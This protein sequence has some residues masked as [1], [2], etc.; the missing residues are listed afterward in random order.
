VQRAESVDD[1]HVS[2]YEYVSAPRAVNVLPR[3][4]T[5]RLSRRDGLLPL[6]LA[7]ELAAGVA[8]GLAAHTGSSA[9]T[10]V[11]AKL[12]LGS[13]DLVTVLPSVRPMAHVVAG[14]TGN[15]A[16]VASPTAGP[17]VPAAVGPAIGPLVPGTVR[18]APAAIVVAADPPPVVVQP[19][20]TAPTPYPKHPARDP[21]AA[22]VT[23]R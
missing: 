14:T 4:V 11:P 23:V 19:A 10:S 20:A 21:F 22:L 16:A 17:F 8:F 1:P 9:V 6:V 3:R 12:T 5:R 18:P 13:E 2:S 7:L 15:Q